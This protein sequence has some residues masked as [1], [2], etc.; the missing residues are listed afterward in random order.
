MA[1][2]VKTDGAVSSS[3]S[4][5]DGLLKAKWIGIKRISNYQSNN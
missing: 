3:A 4:V 5:V 2:G 1:L